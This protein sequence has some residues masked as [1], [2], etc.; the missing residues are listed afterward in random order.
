[1]PV[2][3]GTRQ[4]ISGREAAREKEN[5]KLIEEAHERYVRYAIDP[6]LWTRDNTTFE[7][8]IWQQEAFENFVRHKFLAISTGTGTGKTALLANLI[9]YFLDTRP[10]PKIACTGPSASQIDTA[11]WPEV[12]KWRKK[13]QRLVD[14]FRWTQRKVAHRE[15][16]ENW[17]AVARTAKLQARKDTTESLQGIHEEFILI[18]VDEASG[19]PDQVMNALDGA[20]TTPG[21]YGVLTSNPT[22]RTGYFAR[23]IT[24]KRLQVEHGGPY[25]VMHVSC[26][27]AKYCEPEHI[28]RAI[29]IY[30]KDSDFYRVKV[31]GQLPHADSDVII[32]PEQIF[33]AHMRSELEVDRIT[34]KNETTQLDDRT[35]ISCDPAR[36][37]SDST[38]FYVRIGQRVV[39]RVSYNHMKTTKVAEKGFDLIQRFDPDDMC[40]DAIGIGAGVFD[41]TSDLVKEHNIK[42]TN[43]G[44]PENR[45]KVRLHEIHIG[46]KTLVVRKDKD[47]E[48]VEQFLNL[49]AEL[50]W[51][52]RDH[53]DMI[54]IELVTDALDD[55]LQILRYKWDQGDKKIKLV[56]KDEMRNELKRSPNDA[57]AFTLLFYPDLLAMA[58]LLV[59]SSP[60][61]FAIGA[62]NSL[63]EQQARRNRERNQELHVTGAGVDF[64]HEANENVTMLSIGRK[65]A[66]ARKSS[67]RGR[68]LGVIG[69]SFSAIG[70]RRIGVGRYSHLNGRY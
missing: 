55:E 62:S 35:I 25:K 15:H 7:P 9:L 31:L 47:N 2:L 32:S 28:S 64:D 37:G 19:V 60:A 56:S 34:Q 36:Y 61:M 3:T 50:A 10:H 4:I 24:D 59:K 51:S 33:A 43:S 21:A 53:I 41:R 22:R 58:R 42:H 44:N 40:I 45:Y 1:M 63:K 68:R 48:T 27:Q 30:G 66:G 17:F 57:D 67:G 38:V 65:K 46:G 69:S 26:E 70:A 20:F 29:R 23:V 8:D 18:I 39:K 49:R 6:G 11:L 54:C 5:R 14:T 13:S 16:P 52:L 12:G